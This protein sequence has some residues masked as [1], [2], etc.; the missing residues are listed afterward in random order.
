MAEIDLYAPCPCGSGKKFKWCCQPIHDKVTRVFELDEEGQ[1]EAAL[2]LMDE[3]VAAHPDNA[4]VWGRKAQ[5][6]L[7]SDQPDQ[8][9]QAI[10][11]A[12][13]LNP[14]YAFG[15]F[16]RG[17]LRFEE[18]ELP[19]ALM[20]YR[21]AVELYDPAMKDIQAS[22]YVDIFDLEMKLNHPI[23]A[24]AAAELSLRY[25]STNEQVNQAVET[26]FGPNNPNL[27]PVA[28]KKYEYRPLPADTTA[29]RRA[30]WLRALERAQTGKLTDAVKAFEQLTHDDPENAAAWYNL[31]LSWAWQGNNL[32]ALEALAEYVRREPNEEAA[33]QA[34]SL[35]E[36]LRLGQGM[37]DHADVVEYAIV[38]A[39]TDPQQILDT[40]KNLHQENLLTGIRINKEEGILQAILIEPAGPALTPELQARQSPRAGAYLVL[41]SN[42]LR[43]S[44]TDRSLL[45]S[46]YARLRE[47]IS[48]QIGETIQSRSPA[49]FQI[50]N[51]AGLVIPLTALNEEDARNRVREGLERY[52]E[53]QWSH[54]PLKAL[55]GSTPTD[56]AG[57][58]LLRKKLL[59]V[60]QFLQECTALVHYPYDFDRLRRKLGIATGAAA[61]AGATGAARDISALGPADLAAL[62]AEPLS[63]LELEQ[64]FQ[65]ALKLDAREL[66]GK[67]AELL[68]ARPPYEARP[69]RYP[70]Y[71]HLIAQALG[72][73]DHTAALDFVNAGESY[74]CTNNEGRRRDDY[75]IRRGQVLV[76]SGAYDQAQEVFDRLVQR[77]RSQLRFAAVAAE[78]FV[79][80]RQGAQA[81]RYAQE[82]LA[83]ALRQNNRDLEG[84]FRELIEA[85]Q[86]QK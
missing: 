48:D 68:I 55:D 84:H 17:R 77:D 33:A 59:G 29:E 73:D 27:P 79:S 10:E 37:E 83:E 6:H 16:L 60:V 14:K 43:L 19:G 20:L 76:K 39:L 50:V 22:I 53:E 4:E 26:I 52:F 63:E 49:R 58:P 61:E 32:A 78:A 30:V 3:L 41:I 45:D 54:R 15:Y 35:G 56:A 18:G 72:Q 9:E 42:I 1:Q 44:N 80:A 28:W 2:K 24:H 13:A 8:A 85:A 34:W 11:K 74:D 86:R 5:L 64:A 21:K 65:T 75:E 47:R 31:A 66:A 40:L 38:L 23:A 46:A 70:L 51:S 69:D 12:L 81:L 25:D 7:H 62:T 71:N 82:G 36:V 57:H 67:F